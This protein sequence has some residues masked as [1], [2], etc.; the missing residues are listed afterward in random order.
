MSCLVNVKGR[1]IVRLNKL[2][3][4]VLIFLGVLS[5]LAPSFVFS[6]EASLL[7]AAQGNDVAS[8]IALIEEGADVNMAYPRR[9][10]RPAL[11]GAL[12]CC[13]ANRTTAKCRCGCR[14]YK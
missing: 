13:S 2:S 7:D 9:G 11:G 12:E 10:D 6:D 3:P 5:G 4:K 1:N 8:A 14:C